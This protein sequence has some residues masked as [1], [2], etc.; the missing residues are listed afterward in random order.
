MTRE[1]A[2]GEKTWPFFILDSQISTV[3]VNLHEQFDWMENHLGDTPLGVS[4]MMFPERFNP[5]E[6]IHPKCRWYHSMELCLTPSKRV[7]GKKW[8]KHPT[9]SLCLLPPYTVGAASSL[10]CCHAS[11]VYGLHR[12]QP[13]RLWFWIGLLRTCQAKAEESIAII[14]YVDPVD[15]QKQQDS[16]YHALTTSSNNNSGSRGSRLEVPVPPWRSFQWTSGLLF[17]AQALLCHGRNRDIC[18]LEFAFSRTRCSNSSPVLLFS[19]LVTVFGGIGHP[20]IRGLGG[21]LL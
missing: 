2:G 20:Q 19:L 4:V 18:W 5:G 16:K 10:S 12:L 7:E 17:S 21:H 3:M 13:Q 9:L 15:R 6:K 1:W 14:S 8:A 11:P